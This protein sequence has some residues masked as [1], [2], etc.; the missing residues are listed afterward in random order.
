MRHDGRPLSIEQAALQALLRPIDESL[1]IGAILIIFNKSEKFLGD[2]VTGTIV[3][4]AQLVVKSAN[5]TISEE[6]KSSYMT[7]QKISYLSQLLPD[8]FT[9]IR[10][11]LQRSNG[12]PNKGK[13]SLSIKLS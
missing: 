3:I 12:I 9:I 11:Y 13:V 8:D 10:E 2:L 4:R 6:A 5:L 1:F 7:L